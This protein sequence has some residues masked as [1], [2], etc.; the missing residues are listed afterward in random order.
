MLSKNECTMGN[1]ASKR[2]L[3][4]QLQGAARAPSDRLMPKNIAT[5]I[6]PMPRAKHAW[7][8]AP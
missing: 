7:H 2:A 1:W 8:R 5:I 4:I 6:V 3:A